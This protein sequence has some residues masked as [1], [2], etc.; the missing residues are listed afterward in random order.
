MFLCGAIDQCVEEKRSGGEIDHRRAGD[1]GRIDVCAGK[2][3]SNRRPNVDLPDHCA[4]RCIECI[5]IVRFGHS[6]NHRPARAAFDIKWLSVNIAGNRAIEVEVAREVWSRGKVKRR[7][8]VNAVP[9]RIVMLLRD[10]YLC[11]RP[12]QHGPQ[13]GN[14]NRK[15]PNE[16]PH[17]PATGTP[18]LLLEEK[19]G[20]LSRL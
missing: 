8:D 16:M 9:R 20:S 10:V 1:T 4:G 18:A 19:A 13:T 12:R 11:H 3:R 6:N 14:E 15:I 7:I 5:D 17:T 2:A